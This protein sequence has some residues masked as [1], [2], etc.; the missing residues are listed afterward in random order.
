VGPVLE[1]GV[2]VVV[3]VT[4]KRLIKMYEE[5][6]MQLAIPVF[7]FNLKFLILDLIYFNITPEYLR[8][9]EGETQG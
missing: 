8:G 1:K 2:S 4:K 5:T 3:E 7:F 6:I 9:D